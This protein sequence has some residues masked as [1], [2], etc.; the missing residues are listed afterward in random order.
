[1]IYITGDTHSEFH[2][3]INQRFF[4]ATEADSLIICG[5]FG[6]IWNDSPYEQHWMRWLNDRPFTTLFVSGNHENFDMLAEFPVSTWNG[7]KVQFVREKIIHLMRGQVFEIEGQTFFTMG[8][9]SSHDIEAGILEPTD[10]DFKN[11]IKRLNKQNALYRVNHLSWWKEELPNE[12]EYAEAE[13]NLNAYNRKVDYI[14]THCA[15]TSIQDMLG[16]GLYQADSLTDYLESVYQNCS[17][18]NWFFGH[19]HDDKIIGEKMVLLYEN[20]VCYDS[21]KTFWD[22]RDEISQPNIRKGD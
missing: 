18:K 19:Y 6:G 7:G 10:A 20:I 9:A 2:Y 5:D 17:F 1:M 15:P 12:A 11:K 4:P 22:Y 14:I 21:L 3:R 16:K 8:G 13:K